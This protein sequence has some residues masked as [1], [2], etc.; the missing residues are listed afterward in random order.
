[1]QQLPAKDQAVFRSIVKFY[2]TKQYKKGVKAADSIL[3]KHPEHGETLCMK[4]LTISYLE[5]KEEAYDL[6]RKGLKNDLKSHVCWHVFGLLYRQDRDYQEAVKCYRQALRL[7]PENIQ[8]LRD[9]S[10]LQI[11]GRDLAGFAET[12]RKLLQAKPSNRLNWV[13]YAIAEHLCKSYE[14][15]WTCIDNYENSFKEQ[16]GSVTDYENSELHLYKAAIMEEA[17][18]FEEALEC[19]K[20]NE[21]KITDKIGLW[22]SKGRILMFLGRH[23]DAAEVYKRLIKINSENQQ[24]ALA[25]MANHEKFRSFWPPLPAPPVPH[26]DGQS[27]GVAAEQQVPTTMTAFPPTV[28]PEGMPVYGWLPPKHALKPNRRVIIGSKQHK[29]RA[30]I[31]EPAVSLTDEQQEEVCKFVD[32]L[33]ETYPRSDSLKRLVFFFITGQRFKKRL[34]EY[35][36]GKLRKGVPSLFRTMRSLY[37]T[38]GKPELMQELLHQYISCL[39][40]DISWFG[41]PVGEKANPPQVDDEEPPSSL[42][43]TLM[44]TAEHYDF[45]GETDK[46]LEYVNQAIKHTPTFVEVYSC[47]ARIYRH[48]GD[49][50]TSSDVNEEVRQMDLADRF[51]NCQAVR[52]LLRIDDTQ[53]GME[54]ALLFSKEPDSQEAANLHDMQCMWYES[55]V[56][57]SYM[58]QKKYGKALK[59]FHE[60]FKHFSDI[61]EDQFDFHN[62]CLR[63]TTLKAYVGMLRMQE[64]LYSHKFYRR[65]AK[66]AIRI[67]L[68]LFDA[69]ARGDTTLNGAEGGAAGGEAELSAEDKKKLKHKKKREA[70][71]AEAQKT[72][73]KTSSTASG[74]PKKV[75]EDPDGEKLLQQDPVEQANKIVKILV[76]HCSLEAATHA[77]TY[78]VLSRQGKVLHCLQALRKLWEL[79]GKDPFHYKLIA[80]LSHFCFVMDLESASMPEAVKEVVLAEIAPVLKGDES[81]APFASVADLRKVASEFVNKVEQRIKANTHI[82][83]VHYGLKCLK[84]A[85]RDCKAFCEAWNPP[86]VMCLKESKK[87]LSY[88]VSEFGKDSK[89]CQKFQTRLKEVHPFLVLGD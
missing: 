79:S 63:K 76:N 59:Q 58:R 72:D 38:P 13:G 15:A 2:E 65:A 40:E 74:K 87:L 17:G 31:I 7:D 6:V 75:D 14:F 55:A 83:E 29:K 44:V 47:K 28:H 48:A 37:F 9:L 78:E 45:M 16:D 19:L 77:L 34:D 22:E 30:E 57:R 86:G 39:Q 23:E 67:Y 20:I 73:S 1:M 80:P 36:R 60:T 10:V 32:E 56:G 61:A 42:L 89:A 84:S 70:Q 26:Q 66:D 12:R 82:A 62:Y 35:L 8:I 64:R 54:K 24:Y 43:F 53:G 51:L 52:S 85:G 46:A 71:K 88:L 69:K 18:K 49:V 27:N 50:Q 4:G 25:Y 5:K 3:K 11:H 33:L 81:A 68:E 21:T 41:P